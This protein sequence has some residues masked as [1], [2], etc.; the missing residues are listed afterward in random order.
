[1]RSELRARFKRPCRRGAQ[2]N[3]NSRAFDHLA[4]TGE[5]GWRDFEAKRLGAERNRA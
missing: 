4:G 5:Q 3:M 1:L 2:P